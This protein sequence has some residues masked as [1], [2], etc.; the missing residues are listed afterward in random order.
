MKNLIPLLGIIFLLGGCTQPVSHTFEKI[1]QNNPIIKHKQFTVMQPTAL[2]G[3]KWTRMNY[4]NNLVSI[5]TG[6]SHKKDKSIW[7]DYNLEI[8]TYPAEKEN[9]IKLL[10]ILEIILIQMVKRLN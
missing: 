5:Y 3:E 10:L 9:I 8:R 6:V 2:E 7:K 4:Y 1:D